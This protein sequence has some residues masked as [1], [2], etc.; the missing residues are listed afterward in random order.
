MFF[1]SFNGCSMKTEEQLEVIK[2]IR[3]EHLLL[4]T[5]F[6]L[7]LCSDFFLIHSR[8]ALVFN[9]LNAC[10]KT[11]SRHY[12]GSLPVAVFPTILPSGEVRHWTNDQ[13]T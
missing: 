9:D 13:G 12:A 8:C 4:E 3:P 10:L 7:L 6:T 2:A 11:A 5:G 1:S